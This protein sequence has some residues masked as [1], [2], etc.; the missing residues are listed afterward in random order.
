M[1]SSR[2]LPN[3]CKTTFK[4]DKKHFYDFYKTVKDSSNARTIKNSERI[5]MT[6][7]TISGLHQNYFKAT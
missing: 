6:R 4:Q 5:L 2:L 7:K 1:T 3:Y